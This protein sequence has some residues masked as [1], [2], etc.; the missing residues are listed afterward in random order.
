MSKRLRLIV[1]AK[2]PL[3]GL[4]KTRLIPELGAEGAALLAEK[5]LRYTLD[6]CAR[7]Q[8]GP[9]ELCVTPDCG[10]DFWEH[11]SLAED[12]GLSSQGGGDLGQRLLRAAERAAGD[13]ESVLLL[14]TDCPELTPERLEIAASALEESDA[15]VYPTRDG[16]YA[17]LGLNRVEPALFEEISWSTEVVARQTG[18]RMAQC[19][20]RCEWLETLADIDE[21]A[22]LD[23]LPEGWKGTFL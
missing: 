23:Y 7:A 6:Q 15:V 18:E 16:G 17:L 9:V 11:F 12:V 13:G 1:F 14:G 2:A 5:M 3:P 22:D 8:L 19:D 21:P 4:A 20:M 10:H